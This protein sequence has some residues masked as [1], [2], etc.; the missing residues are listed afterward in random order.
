MKT[1]PVANLSLLLLTVLFLAASLQPHC[2]GSL[3]L[4]PEP[5]GWVRAISSLFCIFKPN[6]RAILCYSKEELPQRPLTTILQHLAMLAFPSSNLCKPPDETCWSSELGRCPEQT[7]QLNMS[8]WGHFWQKPK[9]KQ[10]KTKTLKHKRKA[11][12]SKL[13]AI[14]SLSPFERTQQ[15]IR[16]LSNQ[17][18]TREG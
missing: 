1:E 12:I 16:S 4:F 5:E 15:K 14:V 18:K 9:N 6:G 2:S 8:P 11:T 10:T 13:T 3:P 17:S 7:V